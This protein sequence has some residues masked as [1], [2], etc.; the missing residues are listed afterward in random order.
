MARRDH[1]GEP[2]SE[3]APRTADPGRGRPLCSYSVA[4]TPIGSLTGM[5]TIA[6][7][8]GVTYTVFGVAPRAVADGAA[9]GFP[10][11]LPL[12]QFFCCSTQT[13]DEE[14]QNRTDAHSEGDER[15]EPEIREDQCGEYVGRAGHHRPRTDKQRTKPNA[16][17]MP[18]LISA[19]S[20]IGA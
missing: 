12:S 7:V 3:A 6:A 19:S 16:R 4:V 20:R 10:S 1:D 11:L 17:A 14:T 18:A 9:Q 2:V 13:V 15:A 5:F 8:A